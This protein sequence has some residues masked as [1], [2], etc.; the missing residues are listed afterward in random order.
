[1]NENVVRPVPHFCFIRFFF[2]EKRSRLQSNKNPVLQWTQKEK[3]EKKTKVNKT[4]LG[5]GKTPDEAA[6]SEMKEIG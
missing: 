1:M 2:I 5:T 4:P 6:E 3:R